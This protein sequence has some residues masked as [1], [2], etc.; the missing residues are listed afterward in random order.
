MKEHG[1]VMT[2]PNVL[3]LLAEHKTRTMRVIKD[4]CLQSI[5]FE[6]ISPVMNTPPHLRNGEWVYELQETVDSTVFYK[7]K[8]PYEVGDNLYVKEGYQINSLQVN[9]QYGWRGNYLADGME[10]LCQLTKAESNKWINRKYPHRKT[11]GRF[12]YKSLARIFMTINKVT[13][14]RP[15]DLTVLDLTGEGI[16]PPPLIGEIAEDIYKNSLMMMKDRWMKLW[17]F[18]HGKGAYNK[19]LWCWVYH[20]KEIELK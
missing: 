16:A 20:W 10:F 9:P 2:K 4:S 15:Q 8:C 6:K 13:V 12:M 17:D 18:I 11:S 3:N 7:L 1:I 14:Q 19:N 5:Q